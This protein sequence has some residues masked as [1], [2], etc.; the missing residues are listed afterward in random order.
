[1]ELRAAPPLQGRAPEARPGGRRPPCW[2]LLMAEGTVVREG[3]RNEAL[4]RVA[5][6]FMQR[7]K[8]PADLYAAVRRW[9]QEHCDPPLD[10]RE[11]NSVVR[12]VLRHGYVYGCRGLSPICTREMR[13]RC[14]L[15]ARYVRAVREALEGL[16]LRDR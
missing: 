15:H 4:V 5:S 2:R 6:Y 14:S 11:V 3:W 8:E 12:S 1:M 9:N 16:R 13:S 10:D 7:V